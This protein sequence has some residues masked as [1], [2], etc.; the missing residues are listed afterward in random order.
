MKQWVALAA[1]AALVILAGGW[2]LLVSP[3]RSDA[4][5]LREQADNKARS[6]QVLTTKLAELKAKA[7]ELPAQQ[8]ALAAVASK[9]P[10][11]S[12]MP[13]LIRALNA[14][15]DDPGVELVSMAPGAAQAVAAAAPA[16]TTATTSSTA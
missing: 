10:N 14:A 8:A 9:I 12:A 15:A 4:A 6:N 1:V 13:T 16:A 7:K 2:F 3:K 11:N 5:A